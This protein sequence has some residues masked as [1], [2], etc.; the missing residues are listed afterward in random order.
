[1]LSESCFG[2]FYTR[3]LMIF[4][5]LATLGSTERQM[6]AHAVERG[7][8]FFNTAEVYGPYYSEELL[9]ES[10]ALLRGPVVIATKFGWSPASESEAKGTRYP[11][12]MEKK[13]GLEVTHFTQFSTDKSGFSKNYPMYENVKGVG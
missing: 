3:E 6:S 7:V 2:D 11:A 10:L 13:R 8:T 9:G 5:T 12:K 4:C 1:M